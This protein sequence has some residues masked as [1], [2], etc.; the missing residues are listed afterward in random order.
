MKKFIS[1]I[2]AACSCW[3]ALAE[4]FNAVRIWMSSGKQVVLLL[5][6]NP[7]VSFDNN[8]VVVKTHMDEVRYASSDVVKFTYATVDASSVSH[9]K[10]E[11][12]FAFCNDGLRAMNLDP[13]S[14]ISVYTVDG[15]L[16]STGKT[17]SS[18]NARIVLPTQQGA[19]YIVKTSVA[20]FKITKP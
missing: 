3:S 4:D 15:I 14:D 2:F 12:H 11:S 18:G 13:H 5:E 7:L 16:L 1:I 6:A 8:D 17:D 19:V 10:T 20:T 9:L